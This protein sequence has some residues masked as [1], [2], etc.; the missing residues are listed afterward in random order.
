M[1]AETGIEWTDATWNPTTGCTAVS[2]GCDHCYAETLA[3]RLLSETYLSRS[4]VDDTAENR[5]DPFAVRLWPDRLDQPG[6]WR[7]PRR[8]FVNSMSDLFHADIPRAFVRRVFEVMLEQDHHT[9]QILTKRP[10][11]TGAF[12][13]RNVDLFPGGVLPPHIWIGTSV[14]NQEVIHRVRHL[15]AVPAHLRFLSCEPLLGPLTLELREI[16]WVIAGGESGP[17]RR[18]MELDWV[19]SLRDQCLREGVPFFFKQVGGRTPKAG[20]RKLDG[21]TWNEFPDGPVEDAP[22]VG[23]GNETAG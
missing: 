2:A 17:E 7:K 6:R 13:A 19:R 16:H 12:V 18:R 8:V 20:G 3:H 1:A 11:R 4:P 14:E 10:G 21:R 22:A 9:Y 15:R 5:A 23:G